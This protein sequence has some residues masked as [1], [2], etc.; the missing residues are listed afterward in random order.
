M[1][2]Y[3]F[4]NPVIFFALR[5]QK[6]M[7]HHYNTY[8]LDK[9]YMS[10]QTTDETTISTADNPLAPSTLPKPLPPTPPPKPQPQPPYPYNPDKTEID[11]YVYFDKVYT[12]VTIFFIIVVLLVPYDYSWMVFTIYV[13]TM[14]LIFLKRNNMFDILSWMRGETKEK[15]PEDGKYSLRSEVFHVA[16]QELNYEDAKAVCKA[17]GSRL[18]T[19]K[20]LEEA[21]NKGADWCTYGWS[22]GQNAF[23]PTQQSTF[24]RLQ[25]IKG[26]ERDCGRPGIN[27]GYIT[28]ANFQFGANCYG[29]KPAMTEADK[30][31]MDATTPYPKTEQ[32]IELEKEVAKWKQKLPE[33]LVSPFNKNAWDEPYLRV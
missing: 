26:H 17:Y 4:I 23:F 2:I 31:L 7:H 8:F 18:A 25:K 13:I 11:V 3:I 22:E 28:D 33:L 6:L 29:K 16:N 5:I 19:Y 14:I 15:E 10:S 9:Y 32:D 27:G 20:E 30:L 1:D 12:L 24:D 21:Y